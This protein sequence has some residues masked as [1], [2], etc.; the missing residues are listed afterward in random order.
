VALLGL[1]C[2]ASCSER[3]A[4]TIR[5]RASALPVNDVAEVSLSFTGD[6]PKQLPVDLMVHLDDGRS[7]Q[8][9]QFL[10][11]TFGD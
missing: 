9:H 3:L 8:K 10:Q 1:I 6:S 11:V 2:F 5:L 4:N 7:I